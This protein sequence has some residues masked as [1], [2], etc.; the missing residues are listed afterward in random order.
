MEAGKEGGGRGER[1]DGK[2]QGWPGD[3]VVFSSVFLPFVR[4]TVWV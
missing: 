4:Q 1:S 3:D 2:G